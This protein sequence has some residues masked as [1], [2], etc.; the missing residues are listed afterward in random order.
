MFLDIDT[1][2]RIDTYQRKDSMHN[3]TEVG[4]IPAGIG[5]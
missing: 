1:D 2:E 5:T 3:S 4:E